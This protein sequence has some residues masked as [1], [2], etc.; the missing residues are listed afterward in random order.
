MAYGL[1]NGH[2]TNDV[3]WPWN[4]KPVT[5]IRLELNISK[6]TWARDFTFGT[7]LCLT[8]AIGLSGTAYYRGLVYCGYCEAVRWL[9]SAILATAW[10]RF[11]LYLSVS[12]FVCLSITILS[13]YCSHCVWRI[14]LNII[15]LY[16]LNRGI[17]LTTMCEW[18]SFQRSASILCHI[19]TTERI[20]AFLLQWT[21][22]S[23]SSTIL[24]I[25][26]AFMYS[27]QLK[28]ISPSGCRR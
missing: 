2:V 25:C 1:S 5:P 7:R 22:I 11:L 17:I 18:W 15:I 26:I 4:V 16:S 3:T 28:I 14:G 8:I 10:L 13:L 23:Q 20:G 27:L 12:L 21:Y 19:K 6:T 24:S 9:R